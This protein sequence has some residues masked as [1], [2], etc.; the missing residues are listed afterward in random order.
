MR[1]A[2]TLLQDGWGALRSRIAGASAG[3]EDPDSPIERAIKQ[4]ESA[5]DAALHGYEPRV[6]PGWITLFRSARVPA[7]F[8][9][10]PTMGWKP[11][12]ADGIRIHEI[13]GDRPNIVDEP[14]VRIL[15]EKLRACLEG[16]G[17][18]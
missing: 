5:N 15:A 11:L 14:D 6:Y 7:A 3:P 2:T 17:H 4:V 10:D 8:H 9:G 13:A 12:A 1:R 16:T 18:P